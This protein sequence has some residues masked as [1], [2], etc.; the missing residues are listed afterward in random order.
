MTNDEFTRFKDDTLQRLTRVETKL[1]VVQED[2]GEI[3]SVL[4]NN[5]NGLTRY[6]VE[7]L[8]VCVAAL[9]ALLGV[10]LT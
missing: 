1:D 10:K 2:I 5:T 4:K 3:K 7:G 8:K 6:A 9:L